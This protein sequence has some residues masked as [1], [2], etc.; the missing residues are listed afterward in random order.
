MLRAME[1]ARCAVDASK[2]RNGVLGERNSQ[3][4][5]A[6]GITPE[7]T[8]LE[9]NRGSSPTLSLCS[10]GAVPTR[11]GRV[12]SRRLPRSASSSRTAPAQPELPCR[13]GRP[14]GHYS[15]GGRNK[16][17]AIHDQLGFQSTAC[18]TQQEVS[19]PRRHRHRSTAGQKLHAYSTGASLAEYEPNAA[20][21]LGYASAERCVGKENK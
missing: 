10:G 20:A 13:K 6:P 18:F 17:S 12:A 4:R 8:S 19:H 11:P 21:T 7:T 2:R 1:I 15:S 16:A 5:G 9:I 14:S 3:R